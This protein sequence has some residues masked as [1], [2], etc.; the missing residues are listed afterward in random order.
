MVKSNSN[1]WVMDGLCYTVTD[2]ENCGYDGRIFFLRTVRY[3]HWRQNS[4]VGNG[5]TILRRLPNRRG[6]QFRAILNLF[7]ND[8]TLIRTT[9]YT[10][11]MLFQRK[12]KLWIFYHGKTHGRFIRYLF[13]GDMYMR[14]V[15]WIRREK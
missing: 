12:R 6:R 14:T 3:N 5:F 1:V 2:C 8:R 11:T 15:I 4:V 7:G 9:K 10:K 13:D